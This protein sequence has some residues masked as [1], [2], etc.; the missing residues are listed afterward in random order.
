MK[1][2]IVLIVI[3][4][5]VMLLEAVL[6]GHEIYKIVSDIFTKIF[7]RTLTAEIL[8][9]TTAEIFIKVLYLVFLIW[10]LKEPLFS[11]KTI[12]FE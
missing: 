1:F 4:S 7:T 2:R 10:L 9:A 12:L 8:G 6:T 11:I 3:I 5:L